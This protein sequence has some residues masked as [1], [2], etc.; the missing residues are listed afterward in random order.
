MLKVNIDKNLCKGCEM[1]VISCPRKILALNKTEIN[2]MGYHPAHI[3]DPQK[4]T[5]CGSCAIMC[6]DVVITLEE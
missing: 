5:G 2:A 3:T 6:P 1:C 4:C